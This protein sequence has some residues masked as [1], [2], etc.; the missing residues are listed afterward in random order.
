M[1]IYIFKVCLVLKTILLVI[2]YFY[3]RVEKKFRL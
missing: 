2:S 3:V 1:Q